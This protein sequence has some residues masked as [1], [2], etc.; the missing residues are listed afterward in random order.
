[1]ILELPIENPCDMQ[2]AD[3]FLKGPEA[4]HAL[5]DFDQAL[6]SHIKYGTPEALAAQLKDQDHEDIAAIT[7]QYYRTLLFTLLTERGVTIE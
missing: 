7:A 1:M 2:E 5:W 6:R 3:K 4:H